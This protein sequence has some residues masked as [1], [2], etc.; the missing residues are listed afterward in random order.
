MANL[1]ER[2]SRFTLFVKARGKYTTS[3]VTALSR[4]IRQLS[5]ALRRTLTLDRGMELAQ[6]KRLTVDTTVR[7]Y[8]CDPQSP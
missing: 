7:V 1:V 2:R 3:V 6:Y 4:Q 5:A 8:F